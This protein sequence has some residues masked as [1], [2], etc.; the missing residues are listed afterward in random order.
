M[1]DNLINRPVGDNGGDYAIAYP[2]YIPKGEGQY[3]NKVT[4]GVSNVPTNSGDVTVYLYEWNPGALS[5]PADIVSGNQYTISPDETNIVGVTG[6]IPAYGIVSTSAPLVADPVAAGIPLQTRIVMNMCQANPADGAQDFSPQG[7]LKPLALKDDQQ[8]VLIIAVKP[9][10]AVN[11]D[12]L[13]RNSREGTRYYQTAT[14]AAAFYNGSTRRYTPSVVD[15]FDSG[16]FAEIDNL[17]FENGYAAHMPW[18]EMTISPN[19][20]FTNVE[21]ITDEANASVFVYPNPVSDYLNISINL[22]EVSPQVKVELMDVSGQLVKSETYTDVMNGNFKMEVK[23]ITAGVYT[24]NV[25]SEAGF[26]TRKVVIQ[27]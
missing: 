9:A 6:E 18:I 3:L 23:S 17:I 13:A 15:L 4:F 27:D 25:R 12:V 21:E 2:F 10:D 24:L 16:S 1:F 11:V 5:F 26:T 19:P 22:E 7:E 20:E 14:N 8:Y